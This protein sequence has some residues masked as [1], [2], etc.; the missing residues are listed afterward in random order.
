MKGFTGSSGIINFIP[1]DN[2]IGF[3]VNVGASEKANLKISK[4]FEA[5]TYCEL[6]E[7]GRR[8]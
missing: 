4:T 7:N 2:R 3:E 6:N 8:W 1:R 5:W